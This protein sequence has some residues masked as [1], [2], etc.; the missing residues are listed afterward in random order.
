MTK[1]LKKKLKAEETKR[2]KIKAI[3]ELITIRDTN[4]PPKANKSCMNP[5]CANNFD[6]L[7]KNPDTDVLWIG[8]P[9]CKEYWACNKTSC[10]N[11][12]PSHR[13]VCH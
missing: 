5:I 2:L 1:R 4:G 8:C 13:K 11:M 6:L 7:N 3:D 10:K 12:M 9:I